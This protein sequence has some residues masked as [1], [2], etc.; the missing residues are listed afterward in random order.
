[1]FIRYYSLM[2]LLLT[3]IF[4][5]LGFYLFL[6][7]YS[8]LKYQMQKNITKT[9]NNINASINDSINLPKEKPNDDKKQTNLIVD[10]NSLQN[11][12]IIIR[13]KIIFCERI[14]WSDHSP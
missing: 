1:M 11:N 13:V 8:V 2:K 5:S 10:T 7:G 14:V 6:E 9:S 12:K 4:I 3:L